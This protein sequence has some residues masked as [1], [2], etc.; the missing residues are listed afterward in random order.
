MIPWDPSRPIAS[1]LLPDDEVVVVVKNMS[2]V[3]VSRGYVTVQDV[4]EDAAVASDFVVVIDADSVEGVLT[5]ASSWVE[6]RLSGTV[7]QVLRLSKGRQLSPGQ[8][9]SADVA[10]GEVTIGKVRVLTRDDPEDPTRFGPLLSPRQRYL[11]FLVANPDG[12]TLYPVHTPLLVQTGILTYPWPP[13]TIW[14][15]PPR[16][17]QNLSILEV[18]K[19]VRE[20]KTSWRETGGPAP[21]TR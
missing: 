20:A 6:T 5:R 7:R 16:P 14:F 21:K 9:I 19:T 11:L 12:G 1:R 17:F 2:E 10:P 8:R 18:E 13:P 15:E 4:I 3:V